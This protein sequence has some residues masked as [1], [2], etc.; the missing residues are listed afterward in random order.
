MFR[1]RGM[2]R[3]F[4]R[5]HVAKSL[6]QCRMAVVM[7]LAL[8]LLFGLL[9]LQLFGSAVPV[10]VLVRFVGGPLVFGLGLVL[11]FTHKRY[12]EQNIAF[13]LLCA[14]LGHGLLF[15]AGG[16]DSFYY[17]NV[18]IILVIFLFTFTRIRFRNALVLTGVLLASYEL[19]LGLSGRLSTADF[20]S[21]NFFVLSLTVV[22][23]MA[24]YSIERN[25]RQDF[26]QTK[27]LAR[28]RARSDRLL[29]NILPATVA[30]ELKN[31]GTSRPQR[32]ECVSVMFADF[33]DFSR[34]SQDCPPGILVASLDRYFGYFD[35]TTAK[36][37][38]EKIKTIGDSYMV[39]SGLPQPRQTHAV[40]CVLAAMDFIEYVEML[41]QDG[42]SDLLKL[43]IRIGIHVGPVIA[44]V[45]GQRKFTYDIFG[46]TVNLASRMESAG[47]PNRV[48]ISREVCELVKDF[49]VCEARGPIEIKHGESAEMFWVRGIKPE[50]SLDPAG[51]L[52]GPGFI[53]LYDSL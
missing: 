27:D 39:A 11:T 20:L 10:I 50:L 13:V 18:T 3:M 43:D 30:L 28:E 45:L 48:N 44:G 51:S 37:G 52:P 19:V 53:K 31:R 23:V 9:D 32:F 6:G 15:L 47:A 29:L 7:G 42:E 40:D 46:P 12:L 16:A 17:A 5:E 1:N 14:H 24:G 34:L 2:E 22:G 33:V 4:H 25:I 8:F 35:Q 49:F 38:L 36:Y 26:V 41:R 21:G